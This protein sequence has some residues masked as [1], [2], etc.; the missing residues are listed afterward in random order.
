MH[1]DAMS[2]KR[3]TS[4]MRKLRHL[5][6]GGTSGRCHSS[7]SCH[8]CKSQRDAYLLNRVEEARRRSPKISLSLSG[9]LKRA[10][11]IGNGSSFSPIAFIGEKEDGCTEEQSEESNG[12]ERYW[13][14][15]EWIFYGERE[16]AIFPDGSSNEEAKY[17][18]Q[19]LKV[20]LR[21][22]PA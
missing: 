18:V 8:P 2:G 13:N 14:V 15:H 5:R 6:S 20:L 10:I 3:L 22:S 21:R 12:E 17:S 16:R 7:R 1:T 11:Y 9:N 19:V 4:P